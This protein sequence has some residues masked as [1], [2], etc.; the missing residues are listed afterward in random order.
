[1][2][3]SNSFGFALF[4]LLLR[5]KHGV[6]LLICL[7][8]LITKYL[9][10]LSEFYLVNISDYAPL[11]APMLSYVSSFVQ[12]CDCASHDIDQMDFRLMQ[13]N[14]WSLGTLKSLHHHPTYPLELAQRLYS[15]VTTTCQ[16]YT[17]TA[18]GPHKQC[19]FSVTLCI[20]THCLSSTLLDWFNLWPLIKQPYIHSPLLV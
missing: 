20:E 19:F 14:S 2:R 18:Y 3:L 13:S 17:Q 12:E 15:S 5:E 7:F 10:S 1:M 4:L 16:N 8:L 6:F 11:R 9:L